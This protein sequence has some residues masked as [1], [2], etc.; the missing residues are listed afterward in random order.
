MWNDE[1]MRAEISPAGKIA[2]FVTAGCIIVAG[3]AFIATSWDELTCA[4]G[5]SCEDWAGAAG[6]VSLVSLAAIGAGLRIAWTVWRR[7]VD[8]EGSSLWIWG[9]SVLFILAALAVALLIPVATCPS[10]T[11]LDP[12]FRLCIRG[13]ERL[14]ATQWMWAKWAIAIGGIGIGVAIGKLRRFVVVSA[15]VTALAWAFAL[16]WLLRETFAKMHS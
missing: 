15:I 7:P 14:P 1:P 2:G 3:I 4:K 8:P 5:P 12:V 9:L 6:L 13:N 10:D 11:S 16:T